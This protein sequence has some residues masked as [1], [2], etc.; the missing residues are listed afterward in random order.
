MTESVSNKKYRQIERESVSVDTEQIQNL[1]AA[2][3]VDDL[4]LFLPLN[5]HSF[6]LVKDKYIL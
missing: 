3:S 2:V 1:E 5:D 4:L 6:H